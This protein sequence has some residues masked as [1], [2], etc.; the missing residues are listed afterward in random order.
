M[1]QSTRN[2]IA[3]TIN[4]VVLEIAIQIGSSKVAVSSKNL[5]L[6]QHLGQG[7]TGCA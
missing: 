7:S 2:P 1:R 5:R 3:V 6:Y 4:E